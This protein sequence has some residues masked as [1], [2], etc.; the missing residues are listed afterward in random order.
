MFIYCKKKGCKIE[1]FFKI[2]SVSKITFSF[3][4]RIIIDLSIVINMLTNVEAILSY[5]LQKKKNPSLQ[6]F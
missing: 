4:Y 3:S 1:A 2:F 6:C 5:D